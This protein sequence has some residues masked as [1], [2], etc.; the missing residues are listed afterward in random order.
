MAYVWT[1]RRSKSDECLSECPRLQASGTVATV[2]DVRA[3]ATN[4][5]SHGAL[6]TGRTRSHGLHETLAPV[7]NGVLGCADTDHLSILA[8]IDRLASLATRRWRSRGN[9]S[10]GASG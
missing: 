7:A 4:T 1:V 6:D 5:G 2:P 9:W 8:A 10:T 3:S